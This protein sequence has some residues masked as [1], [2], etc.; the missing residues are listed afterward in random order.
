MAVALNDVDLKKLRIRSYPDPIL[1]LIAQP[2]EQ[3]NG[4]LAGLADRMTDLMVKSGG[5][6]LAAPQVGISLRVI[7]ISLTVKPEDTQ[8]LVNPELSNFQGTAEMEEGCLS[9]PSIRANVPRAATCTLNAQ[10][11]EGNKYTLEADGLLATVI[12]HEIDHLNGI[13]FIDRISTISRMARRKALKQLE[14]EY[15]D[16]ASR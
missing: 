10:D 6:G 2:V 15:E 12:Q 5:I 11:I 14:R 3:F 4:V 8:I 7:V 16:Q 9:V 13:L 1:R